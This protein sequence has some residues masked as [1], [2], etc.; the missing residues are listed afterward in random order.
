MTTITVDGKQTEIEQQSAKTKS[1]LRT[2]PLIGSFREYFL[3]VKGAQE[4]NKQVCG[5][6]YNHEYD[7]FVFVDELGERMRANYLTSAFPKFLESHGLRRMRFHDL[8]HTCASLLL[9]NG[10][11]MKQIQIWLGHS[12]FSTTA[13][14]YAHLDYSAQEA[15]AN[16][17]N[18]M[19]NRP[20]KEEQLA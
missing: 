3:Q 16:A 8:R 13:D 14:I 4:L 7:G 12:T 15:S 6:C 10:I 20:E 11:S 19:F 17:M 18:G 2:L 9:S 1:S 5:N